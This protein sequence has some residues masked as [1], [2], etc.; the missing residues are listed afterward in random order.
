MASDPTPPTEQPWPRLVFVEINSLFG[1]AEYARTHGRLEEA[2]A[3]E[4][5]AK[6]TLATVKEI[7][8]VC[9]G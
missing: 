9:G 8:N 3:L 1:R 2:A 4:W 5:C 7:R 6:A